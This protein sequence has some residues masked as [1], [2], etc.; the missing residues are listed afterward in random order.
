[1]DHYAEL[2]ARKDLLAVKPYTPHPADTFLKCTLRQV[3]ETEWVT[4]LFN[5]QTGGFSGGNYFDTLQK[6][7]VDFNARGHNQHST[8]AK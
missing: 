5:A 3:R 2:L 6:A 7:L 4:H 8:E 1:M